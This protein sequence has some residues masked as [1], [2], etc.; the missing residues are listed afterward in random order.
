M[1]TP[2]GKIKV[3]G[4]YEKDGIITVDINDD[5]YKDEDERCLQTTIPAHRINHAYE[6][7]IEEY[8][9]YHRNNLTWKVS[10]A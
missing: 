9:E 10:H 3:M 1:I 8:I 5:V 4:D 2:V 7:K 6:W